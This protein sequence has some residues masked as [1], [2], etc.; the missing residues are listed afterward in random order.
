LALPDHARYGP[1]ALRELEKLQSQAQADW[2]LTTQ[3]DAVK[4]AG[5]NLPILVAETGLQPDDPEGLLA[6]ALS[7]LKGKGYKF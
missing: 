7:A 5:L 2:L 4:L 3:K 1:K 6:F